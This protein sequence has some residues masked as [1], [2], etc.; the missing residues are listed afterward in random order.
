[1]KKTF[2]EIGLEKN[3]L[4]AINELGFENPMPVQ[5]EVI[6]ILLH[7]KGDIV[8]LSSNRNR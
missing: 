1:M 7:G 4:L 3:V 8:A 5:E 2:E 6:P